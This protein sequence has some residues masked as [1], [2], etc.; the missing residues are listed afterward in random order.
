MNF[1]ELFEA[2]GRMDAKGKLYKVGDY[3]TLDNAGHKKSGKII[4]I[5]YSN[6]NDE[7]VFTVQG[8]ERKWSFTNQSKGIK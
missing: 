2:N 3:V 4:K 5:K 7:T 1:K 8:D 6:N